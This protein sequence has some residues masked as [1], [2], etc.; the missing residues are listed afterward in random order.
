MVKISDGILYA[1]SM[2]LGTE[3]DKSIIAA[4]F[5]KAFIDS[6]LAQGA[7]VWTN[8]LPETSAGDSSYQLQLLHALPAINPATVPSPPQE[9]LVEL[10]TKGFLNNPD[11]SLN[12]D[13]AAHASNTRTIFLLKDVGLFETFQA[14]SSSDT[15]FRPSDYAL[16]KPVF[17]RFA[18]YLQ[19]SIQTEEQHR[20][21]KQHPLHSFLS[22]HVSQSI[23]S[24]LSHEFRNPLNIIL[25][26]LDF[27]SET[28]LTQEQSRYL[29][30]ISETSQ[31]LYYTIKKIFQFVTISL[32]QIIFDRQSFNLAVLFNR[33]E[34]TI[35]L[36]AQKNNLSLHFSVDPELDIQFTEDVSKLTDILIYLIEN[37]IKFTAEGEVNVKAR[38][39]SQT[40]TEASVLFEIADTGKGIDPIHFE[41][42]FSFFGQEDDSI[43][44]QY[45]GL[46]L[47]LS[48]ADQYI[49]KLGGQLELI[50][51]KHKGTLAS[52]K[53]HLKKDLQENYFGLK[54]KELNKALTKKIKV[55]LVDDDVYQ[56]NIGQHILEG[57]NTHTA[58]NGLEAV[59]FLKQN[60]DTQLVLMDIRMPLL[61]GISATRMIRNE[62]KSEA[63]IIAVSGEAQE[64]T[65]EECLAAGMNDF[66]SKPFNKDKL[67][68]KIISNLNLPALLVKSEAAPINRE[69]LDGL[70]ALVVEDDKMNQLLTTRYLK[71]LN[72][73]YEIAGTGEIALQLYKSNRFDFVLLD[74]YL[75]DTDGMKLAKKMKEI[76]PETCLIAYTAH[77]SE[78]IRNECKHAGIDDLILKQY[79][80]APDLAVAVHHVLE[81]HHNKIREDNHVSTVYNLSLIEE[82]VNGNQEELLDIIKTFINYIDDMLAVLYQL[83]PDNTKEVNQT[84]HSLVSSARQFQITDVI[85]LLHKLE[86]DTAMLST[87]EIQEY[88]NQ[89]IVFFELCKNQ[90]QQQFF[91]GN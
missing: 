81:K 54:I 69:R 16:L 50:S 7:S 36:Y 28:K 14:S 21:L 6:G 30:V 13:T 26:Y 8:T 41:Q 31:G 38:L 77:D 62:L 23:M 15:L 44:R 72:C 39:L 89:S 91:S 18:K 53:L 55:L 73:V 52:F 64:A 70:R 75:P 37:A 35:G 71:D 9:V 11:F 12:P 19:K 34:K 42:V 80:K 56:R 84:A 76:N 46:G 90:M 59:N 5:C 43:T 78:Y 63:I 66:V 58:D 82:I 3:L 27:F 79:R 74:L 2:S 85:P 40:D 48:I 60:P 47:G 4:S 33:I 10:Q 68:Q 88:I 67:L 1:L 29:G 51:N 61:D 20:A 17:E 22:H 86:H 83:D 24:T 25:G 32:D 57:W 65:I 87:I 45:G 49:Q